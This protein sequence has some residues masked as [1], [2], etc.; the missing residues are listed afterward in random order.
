VLRVKFPKYSEVN[1]NMTPHLKSFLWNENL[2]DNLRNVINSD[3]VRNKL[4]LLFPHTSAET[5]CNVDNLVN[6][7]TKILNNSC[8][9]VLPIR[10]QK[11]INKN[12]QNINKSGL[13]KIVIH[14]KRIFVI[15][16]ICLQNSPM[17]HI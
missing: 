8:R 15:W 10:R 16:E 13:I 17:T 7:F 1:I 3:E 5:P 2:K 4:D 14:L 9:K 12:T 6:D 11:K